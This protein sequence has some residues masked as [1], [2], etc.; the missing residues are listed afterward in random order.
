MLSYFP[1]ALPDELLYSRLARYHLHSCSKSP[2]QTLDDLF[3]NRSVRAS[4]DLQGHLRALCERI[5]GLT[6]CSPHALLRDTLFGYY[7]SYQP[8]KAVRAAESAMIDGPTAGLHARLGI[9]AGLRLPPFRLRWCPRCHAKAFR[10][11]GEAYWHSAH[12]LP[13]VLICPDHGLPLREANLPTRVG[14]HDF[15]AAT[16]Q[17]CPKKPGMV[18]DW[19]ND[20]ARMRMLQDIARKSAR[21]LD[22]PA[23]FPDLATL[24]SHCRD[25]L[26]ASDL[27]APSGRLRLAHLI[28]VTES[29]L[30][31]LRDILPEA[32]STDWL[33]AMGRK[34]RRAFSPLQHLLFE[35]EIGQLAPAPPSTR[36]RAPEP[37]QFLADDPTF[38]TCLRQAAVRAGSLREA[39]RLCGVDP[40]TIQHHAARLNLA[41]PW[42][43]RPG[44]RPEASPD[45]KPA[46]R[47]RWLALRANCSSRMEMRRKLPADWVWLKRHDPDWLDAHSPTP[48]KRSGDGQPRA[49]WPALD[50]ELAK[51]IRE[52]AATISE[53]R[54][55]CQ[56]TRSEIER[57]LGCPG[58]FSPRLSKLPVSRAALDDS[59]ESLTDFRIRRIRWARNALIAQ[60]TPPAPWRISRLAGLPKALPPA[61]ARALHEGGG[62]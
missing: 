59:A 43:L 32:R 34:H 19:A 28:H 37:R 24:T 45:P 2:K 8:A 30:A 9:A 46:I 38:E 61:V 31:P 48:L 62:P 33:V 56:I 21:L 23:T 17:T 12:Q 42:V 1:A 35:L 22:H 16:A 7:A 58:W 52:A 14:Q 25:R 4:I 5:S 36:K 10:L 6:P 57:R 18:P 41:G 54:P 3:G 27:A 26:I 44:T 29:R 13:G 50:T 60:G 39:A 47:G 20:P 55:P 49:D 53:D 40:R 51:T 15:I 11:H